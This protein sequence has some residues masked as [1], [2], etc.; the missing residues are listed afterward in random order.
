MNLS[1]IIILS[2][3]EARKGLM[4]DENLLKKIVSDHVGQQ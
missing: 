2:F 4:K 3:K 1:S